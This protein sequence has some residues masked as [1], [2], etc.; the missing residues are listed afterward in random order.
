MRKLLAVMMA[1]LTLL[2]PGIAAASGTAP[3]EI[4]GSERIG[5]D[6]ALTLWEDEVAF[7]DVRP[8]E[9]FEAGR[10]PGAVNL[11]VKTA[12][13]EESIGAVVAKNEPVVVYCNGVKCGLSAE[14]IPMLV[15][16]GY[17]TIYYMR[18]GYPGWEQAGYPVE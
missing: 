18:E 15:S 17:T 12:L 8:A 9:N 11:H 7:L 14:A 10:V 1:T 2:A 13:T 16:W 5:L 6:R 4:E 3:M